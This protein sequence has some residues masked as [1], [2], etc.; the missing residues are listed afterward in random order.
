[1]I[2]TPTY[3]QNFEKVLEAYD[4]WPNFHDSPIRKFLHHKDS[5][6]LGVEVWET[7]S[8]IDTNGYYVRTKKHLIGFSFSKITSADL[9]TFTSNN[10]LFELGFSSNTEYKSNGHFTVNLDSVMGADLSGRFTGKFGKVTKVEPL[11]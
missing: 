3:I 5:I 8:E 4:Y 11:E 1:M 7:T 6:E 10:I 9:E 2:E